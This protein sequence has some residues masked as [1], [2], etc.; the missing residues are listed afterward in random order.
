ELA[1]ERDDV[2]LGEGAHVEV[3]FLTQARVELVATNAREVVAL[4]VEEQLVEKRARVLDG[5]RLAGALLLEQLDEGAVFAAGDLGVGLDR[6]ADV[7]RVVEQPQD[8][9]VA[10]VPHG[11]EQI[12][13]WKL[14]LAVDTD[15]DLAL[16]V[17]LE[18]E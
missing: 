18:L 6:G 10:R 5:G 15:E 11:A 13:D 7:E 1:D 12:D 3:G 9:L 8:L 4:G 14:A 2:V 17:D 16:L